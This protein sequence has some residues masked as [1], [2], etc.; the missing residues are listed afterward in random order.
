M[1]AR[2]LL[3]QQKLLSHPHREGFGRGK[4]AANRTRSLYLGFTIAF[5][6]ASAAVEYRHLAFRVAGRLADFLC[7][8]QYPIVT[9]QANQVTLGEYEAKAA[10]MIM[11]QTPEPPKDA[12]V[13]QHELQ[14]SENV[15]ATIQQELA[16]FKEIR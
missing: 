2:E 16:G 8:H 3:S 4:G 9:E 7:P 10:Q 15:L 1:L 6:L 13:Q 11:I 12:I 5:S 14:F